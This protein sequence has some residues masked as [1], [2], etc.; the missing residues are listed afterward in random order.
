M[1]VVVGTP[2]L[3]VVNSVVVLLSESVVPVCMAVTVAFVRLE[4][5]EVTMEVLAGAVSWLNIELWTESEAG[6]W[7]LLVPQKRKYERT[8]IRIGGGCFD[9]IFAKAC[10]SE[11]AL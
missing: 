4:P 1:S 10:R 6:S 8:T 3:D 2:A 11:R 5:P 7:A 9:A